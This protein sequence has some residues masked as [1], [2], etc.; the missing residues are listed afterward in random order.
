MIKRKSS[1][2][3]ALQ[4]FLVALAV[5]GTSS[6]F[7][8]DDLQILFQSG[9]VTRNKNQVKTGATG[10]AKLSLSGGVEIHLGPNSDFETPDR[11]RAGRIRVKVQKSDKPHSFT[12]RTRSAVM[13]VRGTE[14]LVES[15]DEPGTPE[16]GL[17]VCAFDGAVEVKTEGMKPSTTVVTAN[18][19]VVVS[20]TGAISPL[21]AMDPHLMDWWRHETLTDPA[22]SGASELRLLASDWQAFWDWKGPI[23][24]QK[25]NPSVLYS[26]ARFIQLHPD[27]WTRV[28][29]SA[30][31]QNSWVL[32]AGLQGDITPVHY[33]TLFAEFHGTFLVGR[34]STTENT[35]TFDLGVN[36][37][38]ASFLIQEKHQVVVGRQEWT[39]GDGFF[40]G[41][42]PWNPL[43]RNFDGI[44]GTLQFSDSRLHT[45]F[46]LLSDRDEASRKDLFAGFIY[47]RAD[48]PIEFY[49]LG[50]HREGQPSLLDPVQSKS[51]YAVFG[52]K[53][54]Q[55]I[56]GPVFTTYEVAAE[57]L[58]AWASTTEKVSSNESFVHLQLGS[59]WTL[60]GVQ[61][62]IRGVFLGATSRFFQ[63]FPDSHR[64]LGLVNQFTQIRNIRRMG[65]SLT[66]QFVVGSLPVQIDVDYSN[67]QRGLISE[68]AYPI[69]VDNS[70]AALGIEWDARISIEPRQ[71]LF[72]ALAGGIFSPGAAYGA[73]RAESNVVLVQ[74][75]Y[76]F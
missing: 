65:A 74:G 69:V 41:R 61:G 44:L 64:F 28:L 62:S 58:E 63:L 11:L 17:S 50:I 51:N 16:G 76:R 25:I 75:Q 49:L 14:Y 8:N 10:R 52:L 4:L 27:L 57:A 15:L 37:L 67:F 2:K 24:A 40:V 47:N 35:K 72:L 7:A 66:S 70:A 31:D 12:L 55:P 59:K 42:D 48:F 13:G 45:L 33:L 53:G 1:F 20:P 60:G 68:T 34:R 43:T 38:F 46:S 36:Q 21:V 54:V 5:C 18:T 29:N 6:V 32:D 26:Q 30:S 9:D 23:A 73:S 56:W 19:G 3:S 22:D 71:D 39:F